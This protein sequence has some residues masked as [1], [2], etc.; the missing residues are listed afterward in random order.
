MKLLHV[1]PSLLAF[2]NVASAAKS[3]AGSN[4]YYAAG[5]SSSEQ[6]TLFRYRITDSE[7]SLCSCNPARC[8]APA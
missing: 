6:T 2:L 1:L 5:L 8:R 3:F 4:L 7:P